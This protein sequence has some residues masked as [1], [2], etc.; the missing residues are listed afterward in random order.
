MWF[1]LLANISKKFRNRYLENYSLCLSRYLSAS[2]LS[3][4]AVLNMSK[5]ELYLISDVQ[6]YFFF[7]KGMRGGVSYTFKRYSKPK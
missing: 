1:L 2:A 7:E 6:M 3:W 4:D 5:V